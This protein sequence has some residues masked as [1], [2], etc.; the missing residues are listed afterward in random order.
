V[1]EVFSAVVVE[2][3]AVGSGVACLERV[4]GAMTKVLVKLVRFERV[5]EVSTG[6]CAVQLL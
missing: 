5:V 2:V 3:D 6:F 1:S 4:V